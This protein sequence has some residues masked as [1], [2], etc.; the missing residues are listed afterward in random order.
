MGALWRSAAQG[1]TRKKPVPAIQYRRW[2]RQRARV[3]IVAVTAVVAVPCRHEKRAVLLP[4]AARSGP[5]GRWAG[6]AARHRL[7]SV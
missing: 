2:G 6:Q 5:L 3:A 1:Q 4:G 7:Y